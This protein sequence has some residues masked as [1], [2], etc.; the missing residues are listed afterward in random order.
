M[1]DEELE[2]LNVAVENEAQ[3]SPFYNAFS[4]FIQSACK[5]G[6]EISKKV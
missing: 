4:C 1:R 6:I 3:Q 2:H 5:I